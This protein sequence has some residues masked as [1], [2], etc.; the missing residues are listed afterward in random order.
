MRKLLSVARH[1]AA[2]IVVCAPLS[3]LAQTPPGPSPVSHGTTHSSPE[4]PDKPR[5]WGDGNVPATNPST[6]ELAKQPSVGGSDS[7][8]GD[9]TRP[10]IEGSGYKGS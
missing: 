6:N 10:G 5:N 3:A 2:A 7:W 9:P 1:L 4:S 8:G